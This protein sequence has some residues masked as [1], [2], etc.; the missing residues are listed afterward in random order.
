MEAILH[1]LIREESRRRFAAHA[2][3]A[4][5]GIYEASLLVET[6][7]WKDFDCLVVAACT[8][9]TQIAR[10]VA[11]DGL[12][13]DA[14]RKRLAAQYPLEKKVELADHVIDTNGSLEETEARARAV[15]E[16]L[17]G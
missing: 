14:A 4:P 11:R 8:A 2:G 13:E 7:A 12:D 1:P 3:E 17:T 5:L 15:W 16:V 10:L 9:E 6:G